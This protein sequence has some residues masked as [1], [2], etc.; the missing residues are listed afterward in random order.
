M[1]DLYDY[2]IK[3]L[4]VALRSKKTIYALALVNLYGDDAHARDDCLMV[5]IVANVASYRRN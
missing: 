4:K 5:R 3:A 2:H 1:A